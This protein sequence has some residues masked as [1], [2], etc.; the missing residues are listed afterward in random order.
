VYEHSFRRGEDR[1]APGDSEI[2]HERLPPR[3]SISDTSG[4]PQMRPR[5]RLP[6]GERSQ[7]ALR[8]MRDVP[9]KRAER[10]TGLALS[11]WIRV[12]SLLWNIN[13]ALIY[14]MRPP[15]VPVNVDVTIS[16][17]AARTTRGIRPL[18]IARIQNS[19]SS[20]V[21]SLSPSLSVFLEAV[22]ASHA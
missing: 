7:C 18:I 6:F 9:Q 12:R 21:S 20:P 13:G 4:A 15:C 1:P 16:R 8:C 22:L 2:C 11:L 19:I 10:H 5:I 17:G 3:G 14:R